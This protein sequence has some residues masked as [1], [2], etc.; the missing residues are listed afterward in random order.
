MGSWFQLQNN[1]TLLS[2]IHAHTLESFIIDF[3]L[4]MTFLKLISDFELQYYYKSFDSFYKK[5]HLSLMLYQFYQCTIWVKPLAL[6]PLEACLLSRWTSTWYMKHNVFTKITCRLT[7]GE[8]LLAILTGICPSCVGKCFEHFE[9]VWSFITLVQVFKL[10]YSPAF[11][12]STAH[13]YY[14]LDVLWAQRDWTY[15]YH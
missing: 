14:F 9:P 5:V 11:I 15:F 6:R 10:N 3:R 13:N 4:I 1:V 8:I 2:E 12:W 7:E